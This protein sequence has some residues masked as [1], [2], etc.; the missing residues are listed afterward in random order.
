[1]DSLQSEGWTST[2]AEQPF[3]ACSVLTLDAD[4]CVD[5]EPTG[6]LS[7][8]HAV[9]KVKKKRRLGSSENGCTQP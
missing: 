2:V 5:A 6:A 4:G 9:G 7:G 8:E 1:M 3:D